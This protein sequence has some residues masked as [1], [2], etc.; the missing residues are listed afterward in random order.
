MV[1]CIFRSRFGKEGMMF[2]ESLTV[3]GRQKGSRFCEVA[4]LGEGSSI[5]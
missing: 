4:Y 1:S 3:L 5:I 2:V